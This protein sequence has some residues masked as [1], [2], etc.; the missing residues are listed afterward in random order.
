MRLSHHLVFEMSVLGVS[1]RVASNA[2]LNLSTEG[3]I[4]CT[5][6]TRVSYSCSRVSISSMTR[7]RVGDRTRI[8][9]SPL[10]I[11]AWCELRANVP[12]LYV[13]S[14]SRTPQGTLKGV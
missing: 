4:L 1:F 5:L 6:R 14:L 12:A 8:E 3:K 7:Y 13:P 2:V 11:E 9:L 10:D